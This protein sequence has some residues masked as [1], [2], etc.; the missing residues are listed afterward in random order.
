M[1][2]RKTDFF[3]LPTGHAV[4]SWSTGDVAGRSLADLDF[5][6]RFGVVVLAIDQWDE[7]TGTSH[8]VPPRADTVLGPKD[9]IVVMGPAAQS[10]RMTIHSA[11]E[12]DG[13]GW[14][15]CFIAYSCRFYLL[16]V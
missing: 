9:A 3:E 16:H 6:K 8:R 10:S 1:D 2:D 12:M 7:H 5:T 4:T 15:F 14:F 13:T 11:S